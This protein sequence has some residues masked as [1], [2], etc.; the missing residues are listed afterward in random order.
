MSTRVSVDVQLT[1]S[2]FT[3]AWTKP[4]F[5]PGVIAETDPDKVKA[6]VER[7]QVIEA[8]IIIAIRAHVERSLRASQDI[9]NKAQEI[10]D[11]E[12][13]VSGRNDQEIAGGQVGEGGGAVAPQLGR[14]DGDQDDSTAS[15]GDVLGVSDTAGPA[16]NTG[17]NDVQAG[18]GQ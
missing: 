14:Q 12:G 3:L 15:G 1:E 7:S 6:I 16:A 8:A 11:A 13:T 18:A 2:G 4:V 10:L 9:S 17:G 5:T